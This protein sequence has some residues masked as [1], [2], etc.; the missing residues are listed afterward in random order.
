MEPSVAQEFLQR[1]GWRP[2]QVG[3]LLRWW[4]GREVAAQAK[5]QSRE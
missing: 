3:Y 5:A 2:N 1:Q 4:I